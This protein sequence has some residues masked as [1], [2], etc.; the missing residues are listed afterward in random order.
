MT[1]IEAVV[2]TIQTSAGMNLLLWLATLA[3]GAAVLI[4]VLLGGSAEAAGHLWP[5]TAVWCLALV[6]KSKLT[7]DQKREVIRG[8]AIAQMRAPITINHAAPA[9]PIEPD[10]PARMEEPAA[11]G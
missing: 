11:P 4:W 10:G 7:G 3:G 8:S 9:A 6:W 2:K 5:L 1:D